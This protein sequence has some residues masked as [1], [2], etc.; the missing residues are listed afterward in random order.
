MLCQ[1]NK[2]DN[3]FAGQLNGNVLGN[4]NNNKKQEKMWINKINNKKNYRGKHNIFHN[5]K[6]AFRMRRRKL[7]L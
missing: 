6:I 2:A 4:Y 1:A 5:E 3:S 7:N